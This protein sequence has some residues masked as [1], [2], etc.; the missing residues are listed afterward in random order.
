MTA[1]KL[2]VLKRELEFLDHGGYRRNVGSRQPVFCME[3]S[4]DWK[5][6]LFLEDSPSCPKRKYERCDRQP[7]CTLAAFVPDEHKNET[8]PCR[9]I[10]LNNREETIA[11]LMQEGASEQRI[12]AAL[13]GWLIKNIVQLESSQQSE[14]P[15]VTTIP[16]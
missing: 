6:A 11:S 15:E 13:R 8:V 5:P 10:P 16:V 2:V 3:T 14:R 9:H 7:E 1:D 12:E 4:V